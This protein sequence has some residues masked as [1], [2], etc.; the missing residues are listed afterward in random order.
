MDFAKNIALPILFLS[1]AIGITSSAL[2]K[3]TTWTEVAGTLQKNATI[4]EIPSSGDSFS[5]IT[6]KAHSMLDLHVFDLYSIE[7]KITLYFFKQ[8]SAKWQ[9]FA[10]ADG[11]I[12]VGGSPNEVVLLGSTELNFSSSGIG[13]P[14]NSF[15]VVP[16]WPTSSINPH[17]P[18]RNPKEIRID[19][20]RINLSNS[21]HLRVRHK[22]GCDT[23]CTQSGGID[24]DSDGVD[25][26]SIWRPSSGHWAIRKSS[27]NET[28]F[29]QWGL[30]DDIPMGGD[31]T[32]DGKADL[33]VWRPSNGTWYVCT[34]ES[35][36]NCTTGYA[37]QFGLPKDKPLHGDFDG[38]GNLDYAIW[39]PNGGLFFYMKS[40]SGDII[41]IQQW[42]LSGDIPVGALS[43]Q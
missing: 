15:N 7:R 9:V 17:D 1:L 2:A 22:N 21:T 3:D 16:N 20:S 25:D 40:G 32:G 34:S 29:I 26:L 30:P 43:A 5:E 8:A 4:N 10:Y 31:Y 39:R 12:I 11:A 14:E 36:F 23:N 6:E 38:D 33:V 18:L 41:E 19:L 42:G 35:G 24:F 27:T 28:L 13:K 37:Q